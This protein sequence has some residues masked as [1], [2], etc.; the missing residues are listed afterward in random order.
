MSQP[1][2]SS[3]AGQRDSFGSNHV[4]ADGNIGSSRSQNVLENVQ[5]LTDSNSINYQQNAFNNSRD[6][7]VNLNL[8]L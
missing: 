1:E 8:S 6:V 5:V 7:N 2:I 3:M 4:I